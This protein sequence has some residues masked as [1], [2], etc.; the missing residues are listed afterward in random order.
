MNQIGV[1]DHWDLNSFTTDITSL[2]MSPQVI[3]DSTKN[4]VLKSRSRSAVDGASKW[5]RSVFPAR[6][7]S[8]KTT[9]RRPCEP[10]LSGSTTAHKL[11]ATIKST[12]RNSDANGAEEAIVS[13]RLVPQVCHAYLV[14]GMLSRMHRVTNLTVKLMA[15]RL[16]YRFEFRSGLTG[17]GRC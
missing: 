13:G 7:R 8:I 4:R 11:T 15:L 3:G 17:C 16:S 1:P 12:L 6:T 14:F 2:K 5:I 10:D 9:A